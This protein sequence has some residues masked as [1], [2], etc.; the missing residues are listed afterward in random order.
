MKLLRVFLLLLISTAPVALSA[1]TLESR[2]NL[3][4]QPGEQLRYK[5][6]YGFVT[7][8]EATLN[9]EE[10]DVRFD[11]NP[12]YHLIAQGKTAGTFDFFYK[13]RDRYDSYI[14]RTE[15]TPYLYTEN[16]RESDYKRTD[17]VRFYQD[18]KKIVAS[19]GT[20]K[21]TGQ[22]FDLVS[23]FYFARSLDLTGI[24]VGEKLTMNY[25]LKDEVSPLSIQ[26]L[27]KERVKTSLGYF[28]CL[29]F[30]PAIQPGRIFKKDSK[31][32]LWISDDGN[33]IPVKAQV[34]ILV[35]SVTLEISGAS[36]LKYASSASK[37]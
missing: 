25:F 10:S 34:E 23:A 16:I 1:Q 15:L 30:S 20:F 5:L 28:N 17:K 19:R 13:V 6:K 3:A 27:G 2:K 35:G 29:K 11:N 26:Y 37:R 21:G 9:V 31:L 36:G 33:R 32:Y 18:Q 14:D 7:A 8:A 22:T 24:R 12:V 4:F